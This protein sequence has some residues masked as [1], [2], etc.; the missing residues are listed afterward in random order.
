MVVVMLMVRYSV[1]W[2]IVE[3]CTSVISF[4]GGVGVGV[5]GMVLGGRNCSAG[6]T[7]MSASSVLLC[8]LCFSEAMDVTSPSTDS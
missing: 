1:G 7:R 2:L 3:V 8:V 4:G 6:C 5:G